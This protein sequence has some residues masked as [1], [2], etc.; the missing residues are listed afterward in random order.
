M[1]VAPELRKLY[2]Y[3]VE[4]G[5]IEQ[6]D[7]YN[8]EYLPIFSRDV[9]EQIKSGDPAWSDQVPPEVA[10]VIRR[11]GFFGYRKPA[12]PK[13]APAKHADG[14]QSEGEVLPFPTEAA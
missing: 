11:R 3:L 8:P 6:L 5:C 13:D 9:I 4:K 12:S 7:N 2:E 1:Q 14:G 10:E